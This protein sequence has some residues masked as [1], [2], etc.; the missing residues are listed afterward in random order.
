MEDSLKI[1]YNEETG[2]ITLEWDPEDPQWKFLGG[3]TP[4]EIRDMIMKHAT[5]TL[6]DETGIE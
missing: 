5:E 1:D 2:E 3:L 4:E 6:Q